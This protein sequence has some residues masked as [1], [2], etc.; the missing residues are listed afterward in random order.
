MLVRR[1]QGAGNARGGVGDGRGEAQALINRDPCEDMPSLRRIPYK[2][3]GKRRWYRLLTLVFVD[4]DG[5]HALN[6]QIVD[7]LTRLRGACRGIGEKSAFCGVRSARA[8]EVACG[9]RGLA[10][11]RG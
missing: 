2:R 7:V 3:G 1:V 11:R 10:G 4:V 9:L 5:I 8:A 6:I